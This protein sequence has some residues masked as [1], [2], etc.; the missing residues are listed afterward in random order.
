M[1]LLVGRTLG[2]QL[3]TAGVTVVLAR[4]LTPADYGLFA[5]ALSVQLVGQNVAELGLPAA[6]VR[7]SEPPPMELQAATMGFLLAVTMPAALG[8]LLVAFVL[9]PA[10][11]T[12][13]DTVRVIAI[14]LV[15]VP[16]YAAR[17]VPMAMMDREMRFGRVAAV[18]AA[19]TIGFNAFALAAALSGI[20]VFSLAGA[21]PVGAALGAL[22]AWFTQSAARMPRLDLPRVRPLIGFGSRVSV[23]GVLYLG[24]DLG[25]V[26]VI[27]AIGGAPMAGFY[28]MA[29]RLFSFPTAL[30][31]AVSRVMLPTL[32]Q[33]GEER[34]AR[35]GRALGQIALVCGL[36][37]ALVAG[38]IQPFISVVLG[39]EWLPTSD[40]VLYGSLAMLLGA[41]IASPINSYCLAEGEPNRPVAAIAAELVVGFLLVAILVGGLDEVGIGIS[42]SIGSALAA[43]ILLA[44]TPPPVK[45]GTWKVAHVA[46]IS[47]L[48]A[49]A[50]QLL[51]LNNDVAGLIIAICI[52]GA[53][54]VALALAFLRSDVT[55][56]FGMARSLL[57][58][59]AQ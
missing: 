57:P 24:R 28:G 41:S 32:S 33:S 3:L 58:G 25:Y 27:G 55:R 19:D 56:A 48:A 17:A 44:P 46:A 21:V 36:P 43:T 14:T 10:L 29:K 12:H 30:A 5:I 23:L 22:V 52:S 54:W 2:F 8:L 31:A 40:I 50:A 51:S 39:S 9:L 53:V 34:L 49:A 16:I 13:S 45:A 37:L 38:A 20:G 1:T 47:F 15:A 59:A 26:T 6:L 42:M 18:E 35:T 7:M 4:L 11:G